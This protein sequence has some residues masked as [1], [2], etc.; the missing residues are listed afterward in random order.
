MRKGLLGRRPLVHVDREQPLD[1]V[2]GRARDAPPTILA[3]VEAPRANVR[4]ILMEAYFGKRRKE[5][6]VISRN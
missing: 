3:S 5:L 2:L 1:E 6:V 4:Q